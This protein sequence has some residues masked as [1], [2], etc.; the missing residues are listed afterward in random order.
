MHYT[1][2]KGNSKLADSFLRLSN[3]DR[4]AIL[5]RAAQDSGKSANVLEKDVWVCWTLEKLAAMPDVP[6]LAFKGGTSLSKVYNSIA[7]FSE[8]VD[9]TLDR[10][11]LDPSLDPFAAESRNKSK[12]VCA[13]LDE[14]LANLVDK[15]VK[16]YFDEC[17]RS[18]LDDADAHTQIGDGDGQ[19][20]IP[21]P[22]CFD[23]SGAYMPESV[24]LELGGKNSIKPAREFEITPYLRD[25][26][27]SVDYP[28]PTVY[29]L[30][31]ERTFWEKATLIHSECNRPEPKANVD[32]M[33]RHW[34]DL[35]QLSLGSVGESALDDNEL[36]KDVVNQKNVLYY[37]GFS[38]YEACLNGG[39]RLVPEGKLA[40]LLSD[41]FD[42]MV[43]EG[44]F[45]EVPGTFAGVI[46]QLAEVE[47]N[48]NRRFG[49]TD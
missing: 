36:L 29:V 41:D 34:Y 4:K 17:L 33:S 39:I 2:I 13:A 25:L 45:W 21:Y 28:R 5:D 15:T 35:A 23:R 49:L 16:P 27:P 32:Q 30:A 14:L 1:S 22:S 10:N 42:K 40:N 24:L 47:A 18:E 19:L 38:D 26:V 46:E 8:D 43:S 3:D 48:I 37:A 7:R 11:A 44:M 9:V 12:K 20:I 6:P 31:A